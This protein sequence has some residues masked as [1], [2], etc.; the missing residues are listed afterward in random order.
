MQF[1]R[2][3]PRSWAGGKPIDFIP[4]IW[5]GFSW[6]NMGA[7]N[8]RPNAWPRNAGQ[9]LWYQVREYLKRDTYNNITSLYL[10]MFDEYG[11]STV[12]MKAA[13]DFFDVP[14]EQYFLTHAADGTWLSSDYYM[15][16]ANTLVQSFK[17]K[18]SGA[19]DIGSLNDIGTSSIVPH[20]LGPVFWRNSFERRTGRL[21]PG[22]GAFVSVPHLQIDVGVPQ[23]GVLGVAQNVIVSEAFTVNRPAVDRNATSDNYSPPSTIL[24][25]VYAS[26]DTSYS[27]RSGDSVFRLAG[28]RTA[29]TGASY[30]YK[31]ADTRIRIESGMRLSYWVNVSGLGA[32]VMVDLLLDNGAYLSA[33][34]ATQNTGS[35]QDGWQQKTL[36]IP[37]S[38]NGHY[39]TAV[40]IAYR[41]SSATTGNFAALIDDIIIEK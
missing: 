35:P 16:L 19:V 4:A 17:N 29:G 30:N 1:C 37:A 11:E 34:A 3:N 25:M 8:G 13:S 27:A 9:F 5:P 10:I 23:G 32:N 12:W 15:R 21:R 36:S 28:Q 33:T 39:I 20:S 38:L 22:E 18:G 31:I 41:D 6:T 24:G 7:R 40:I 14:L 26:D 2:D